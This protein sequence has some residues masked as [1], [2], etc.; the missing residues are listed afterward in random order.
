MDSMYE[1]ILV[2]TDGGERMTDAIERTIEFAEGRKAT[3][4]AVSVIDEGTFLTLDDELKGEVAAELETTASEAVEQ[5]AD[6]VEAAG[7]NSITEVRRGQP[8][9]EIV[10]YATQRNIDLI[11]IGTRGS[12][13]YEKQMLGSV[14]KAVVSNANCPVLTVPLDS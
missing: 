6:A 2:A 9:E 3:V 5:V 8:D 4:H 10:V 7:L 1:D 13:S 11:V 14:S 12:E